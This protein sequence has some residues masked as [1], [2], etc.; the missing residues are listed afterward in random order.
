MPR[1]SQ[2]LHEVVGD[3]S[4]GQVHALHQCRLHK[5]V[6]DRHQ[7]CD[8][9]ARVH[10]E[11]AFQPLGVQCH[12]GLDRHIDPSKAIL[13]EHRLDDP[14]SVC[15][16]VHRRL[17]LNDLVLGGHDAQAVPGVLPHGLHVV[18]IRHLTVRDGAVQLQHGPCIV[19]IVADHQVR[20][21]Q[22]RVQPD[23]VSQHRPAHEIRKH[24]ARFL[25]SGKPGLDDAGACVADDGNLQH[26]CSGERPGQPPGRA[27]Q[28]NPKIKGRRG[29]AVPEIYRPLRDI[30]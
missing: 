28:G 12:D 17:C 5:A 7:V 16:W 23:V 20:D 18:P 13:L 10:H 9:V 15:R 21:R 1:A 24:H 8:T 2:Q 19:G 4:A 27:R 14:L 29:R 6:R 30:L 25:L 22:S 11:A 26:G 3:M